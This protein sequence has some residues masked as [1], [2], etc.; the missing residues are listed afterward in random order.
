MEDKEDEEE[1][2]HATHAMSSGDNSDND[3]DADANDAH[4]GS[5]PLNRNKHRVQRRNSS[6]A[7]FAWYGPDTPPFALWVCGSDDL[8]DG[9]RLLRRFER[10][11]EPFVDV[12]HSKIIEGYEHLDVIWA[13]DAIEKVG[14]E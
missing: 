7:K 8:V 3:Q 2:D 12:V 4:P 13:M 5:E 6:N 9:R 14:K 10:G 11:R 1:D